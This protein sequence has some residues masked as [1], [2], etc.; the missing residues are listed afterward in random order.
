[1]QNSNDK[2]LSDSLARW[3]PTFIAIFNTAMLKD[4]VSS[5]PAADRQ[6]Y[7][8]GE[9]TPGVKTAYAIVGVDFV[10]SA[11]SWVIGAIAIGAHAKVKGQIIFGE[12][13][14]TTVMVTKAGWYN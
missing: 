3:F 4:T 1:M 10:L 5:E 2:D 6:F 11:D 7:L 14:A 8:E 9:I 12:R 13:Q